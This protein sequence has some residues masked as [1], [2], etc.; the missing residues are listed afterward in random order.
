M[1]ELVSSSGNSDRVPYAPVIKIPNPS[2]E[3]VS[4]NSSSSSNGKV[5][6]ER[7]TDETSMPASACSSQ[8]DRN[9]NSNSNSSSQREHAP[10]TEFS[11]PS[12]EPASSSNSSNRECEEHIA[13]KMSTPA[14]C[15]SPG[16]NSSSSNQTRVESA[17]QP[18]SDT[19][20]ITFAFANEP[21]PQ[22]KR[23]TDRPRSPQDRATE[24]VSSSS[25][26]A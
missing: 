2:M 4:A 22:R 12:M 1:L 18:S 19:A 26:G 11:G 21:V 24:L 5:C 10:T 9:S 15:S 14:P 23:P 8:L 25:N 6:K 16:C 7:H 20:V 17:V 3:P 13:D